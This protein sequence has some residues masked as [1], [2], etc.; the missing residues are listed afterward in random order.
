M[1]NQKR[2][3]N[4]LVCGHHSDCLDNLCVDLEEHVSMFLGILAH[5]KK[6]RVVKYTYNRSGQTVSHYVHLVLIV[7]LQLHSILLGCLGA[8]DGTF[9]NVYV[10]SEDRGHYRTR[11]G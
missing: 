7:V 4:R 9:V 8:L 1:P 3:L 6:N 5:Q 10:P 2:E 11:K